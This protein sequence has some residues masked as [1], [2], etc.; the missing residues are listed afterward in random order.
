MEMD[1]YNWNQVPEEEVTPFIMRQVIHTP[2]LTILR[3]QFKKGAFVPLHDHVHEQITTIVSGSLR[4]ATEHEEI[5]LGPG[6]ISRIPSGIPHFAE[7]LEDTVGI[8]IFSPAR[9]DWQK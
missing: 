1:C 7:A 9:S 4:L 8:D 5:L 2:H 6:G 3:V